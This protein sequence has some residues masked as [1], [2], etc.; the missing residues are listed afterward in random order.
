MVLYGVN[1]PHRIV[2]IAT[3][4]QEDEARC[5]KEPIEKL[6]GACSQGACG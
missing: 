4:P 2:L 6:M 1:E 3:I 5:S